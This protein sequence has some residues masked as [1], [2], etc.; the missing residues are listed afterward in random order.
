MGGFDWYGDAY[1]Q[2]YLTKQLIHEGEWDHT[3]WLPFYHIVC[4]V[5]MILTGNETLLIPKLISVFSSALSC[6]LVYLIL[7]KIYPEKQV[8]FTGGIL[9]SFQPAFVEWSIL[10]MTEIFTILIVL[11]GIY[12]YIDERYLLSGIFIGLA[13]LSRFEPWIFAT[14]LLLFLIKRLLKDFGMFKDFLKFLIPVFIS[15]IL[16]VLFVYSKTGDLFGFWYERSD[17]LKFDVEFERTKT[18]K[19]GYYISDLFFFITEGIEVTFGVILFAF[20]SILILKNKYKNAIHPI[21]FIFLTCF[22]VFSF[23]AYLHRTILYWR[24]LVILIP[25]IT[26]LAATTAMVYKNEKKKRTMVCLFL[27]GLTFGSIVWNGW[28]HSHHN[29]IWYESEAGK[30]FKGT[31]DEGNIVCDSYAFIYYS[32]TPINNILSFWTLEWFTTTR[33]ETQLAQWLYN[34]NVKYIVWTSYPAGWILEELEDGESDFSF[35]KRADPETLQK[36]PEYPLFIY[37]V[38]L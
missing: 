20:A 34:N 9:L 3:Y 17:Q 30:W 22:I 23:G 16:W 1:A 21:Y 37:K 5:F 32:E 28:F 19:T 11:I 29:H 27:I 25:F 18:G 12:F 35:I 4:G 14:V 26:I 2:W 7:L 31:Y 38:E 8:A 13:V 36:H 10:A 6:V 24:Y 33:N 15:G